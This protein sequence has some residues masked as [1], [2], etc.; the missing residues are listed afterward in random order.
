M[1]CAGLLCAWNGVLESS[2]KELPLHLPVRGGYDESSA[3]T[4]QVR[5]CSR[6]CTVFLCQRSCAII[7]NGLATSSGTPPTCGTNT[8][9]AQ[10]G[11]EVFYLFSLG[12]NCAFLQKII[13]LSFIL[14][15]LLQF[16]KPKST[17]RNS[18]NRNQFKKSIRLNTDIRS[19]RHP[20]TPWSP[21][22]PVTIA[23]A[24]PSPPIPLP[25][26]L[27]AGQLTA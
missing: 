4:A 20:F 2:C 6:V 11:S 23:H 10:I 27:G 26:L 13:F 22:S 25:R 16:T 14:L 1:K 8:A 7:M 12:R 5:E 3:L 24:W 18:C 15:M 17:S 19:I 21:P 9:S